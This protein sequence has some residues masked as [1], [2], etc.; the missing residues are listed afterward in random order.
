MHFVGQCLRDLAAMTGEREFP[1]K[2]LIV[3]FSYHH[4]NT[5]KVA[6]AIGKVLDAEIKTPQQI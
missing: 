1:M 5:Q 3:V 6:E 2:T 4:S